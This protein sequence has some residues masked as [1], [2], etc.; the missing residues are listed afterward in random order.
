M[1]NLYMN[2]QIISSSKICCHIYHNWIFSIKYLVWNFYAIF[3]LL[4]SLW[5]FWISTLKFYFPIISFLQILELNWSLN[6]GTDF[7]SWTSFIC[8]FKLKIFYHTNYNLILP[9]FMKIFY[10]YFQIISFGNFF[11]FFHEQLYIN[12]QAVNRPSY[13]DST[14]LLIIQNSYSMP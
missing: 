10:M 1:K 13:T 6:F 8:T 11:H 3:I 7:I 14:S 9:F 12:Y 4:T 5:T 2:F